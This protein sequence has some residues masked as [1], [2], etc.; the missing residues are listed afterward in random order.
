MKLFYV[1]CERRV[2][3]KRKLRVNRFYV[4][5]ESSTDAIAKAKEPAGRE[6]AWYAEEDDSGVAS[7]GLMFREVPRP[8]TEADRRADMNQAHRDVFETGRPD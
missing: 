1:E 3:G 6:G 8:T 7:L 2:E 4:I 5:A